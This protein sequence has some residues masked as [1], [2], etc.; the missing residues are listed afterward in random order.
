MPQARHK[1]DKAIE[2]AVATMPEASAREV[3]ERLVAEMAKRGIAERDWPS[4]ATITRRRR[5]TPEKELAELRLV[6]WPEAFLDLGL[7]WEM[8]PAVIELLRDNREQGIIDRPSI[9]FAEWFANLT[10]SAPG[11]S[12][13]RRCWWATW[14]TFAD[15]GWA[16]PEN[17]RRNVEAELCGGTAPFPYEVEPDIDRLAEW[18][19]TLVQGRRYRREPDGTWVR[20][21]AEERRRNRGTQ[22]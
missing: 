16:L 14:L 22:D 11:Q 8:A 10:A 13:E 1:Y 9:T 4:E 17:I 5:E 2:V 3:R 20:I 7:A 18:F 6:F 12:V 21:T 19:A 15:W